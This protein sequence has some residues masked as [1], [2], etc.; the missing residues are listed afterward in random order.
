M[1]RLQRRV[2]RKK[3]Q[4]GLPL[5]LLRF[6]CLKEAHKTMPAWGASAR[7]AGAQEAMQALRELIGWPSQYREV[8]RQLQ[9]LGGRGCE[10]GGRGGKAALQGTHLTQQGCGCEASCIS[11]SACRHRVRL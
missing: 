9:W 5:R 11:L 10:G 8:S 1:E 4:A 2:K 3:R 7:V 6:S